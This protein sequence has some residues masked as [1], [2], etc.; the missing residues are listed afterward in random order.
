MEW[1]LK[2]WNMLNKDL[3]VNSFHGCGVNL[4]TD[5]SEDEKIH[6]FKE[7]GP[8]FAGAALLKDQT[9]LLSDKDL[10]KDPFNFDPTESD[11][12]DANIEFNILDED[13]DDDEFLTVD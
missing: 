8:C 11:I 7:K 2:A 3:I 12:E 6:C 4:K 9:A 5:G 13:E 10:E 1:V